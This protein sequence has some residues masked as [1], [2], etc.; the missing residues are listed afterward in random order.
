MT[1]KTNNDTLQKP[2]VTWALT[3]ED[4]RQCITTTPVKGISI[5]RLLEQ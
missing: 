4:K 5:H 3:A 1:N 2:Y